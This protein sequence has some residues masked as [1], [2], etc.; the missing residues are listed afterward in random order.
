MSQHVIGPTAALKPSHAPPVSI[1]AT[2]SAF[3][4]PKLSDVIGLVMVSVPPAV[5]AIESVHT[6]LQNQYQT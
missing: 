3:T 5:K 6:H 4:Y 2:C 1:V